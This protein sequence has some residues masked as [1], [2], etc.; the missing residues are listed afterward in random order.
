MLGE[1]GSDDDRP[2]ILL[3]RDDAASE[4]F[5]EHVNRALAFGWDY[6][7]YGDQ[8]LAEADRLMIDLG[9]AAV[10]CRWEADFGDVVGEQVPFYEGKPVM[11]SEQATSLMGGYEAGPIPGVQM[12]DVRQG[13]IVWEPLS[14]FNLLPPPGATN[15]R[16]FPWECIIWP[17]QLAEVKAEF[18]EETRT[19]REDT[20]ISSTLGTAAQRQGSSDPAMY[21][22][23]EGRQTRLRDHVWRFA[24]FE[25]PSK[26]N[27]RGRV[28]LR[29]QRPDHPPRRRGAAVPVP[30]RDV[31][32]G[33][34]LPALVEGHGPLLESRADRGDEGPAADLQQ[35]ARP[36]RRDHRPRA[37][38]TCSRRRAPRSTVRAGRWTILKYRPATSAPSD[39]RCRGSVRARG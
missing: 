3:A 32:V 36:D 2:E 28:Y 29:R 13:R 8:V 10:R 6:E 19:M 37:P 20:D 14:A 9:T 15:E 24:F 18:P 4:D 25:R 33:D 11:D 26:V 30:G 17:Q 39:S 1:L 23:G 34:H 5:Q 22:I 31:L 38:P 21:A 35:A 7:F 27:P 12:Q 16:Y